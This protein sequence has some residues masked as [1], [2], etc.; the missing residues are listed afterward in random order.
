M[1]PYWGASHP[2]DTTPDLPG[3]CAPAHAQ[4]FSGS[5]PGPH[6]GPLA[7]LEGTRDPHGILQG[8]FP[9]IFC[10]LESHFFFFF[11]DSKLGTP[12]TR[13]VARE[14]GGFLNRP[15]FCDGAR[16]LRIMGGSFPSL[17]PRSPGLL[18]TSVARTVV[19]GVLI[20]RKVFREDGGRTEGG[21]G[22]F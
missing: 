5:Y 1:A 14:A 6:C 18:A 13:Q 9:S 19:L 16:I 21:T 10:A 11:S 3:A 22:V 8:R 17:K 20:I 12:V 4:D 2:W 15:G 7:G